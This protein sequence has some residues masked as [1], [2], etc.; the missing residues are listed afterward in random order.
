MY[1]LICKSNPL[2]VGDA[3]LD[4]LPRSDLTYRSYADQSI[5][6]VDLKAS[7]LIGTF[8]NNCRFESVKFDNSDIEGA[9]FIGCDFRNCTF[10]DADIRSCTFS[11]CI[12][13]KCQ[14]DQALLQDTT[15]RDSELIE[16]SFIQASIHDSAFHNSTLNNCSVKHSSALHNTFASVTFKQM[17]IADCTFLY[18]LFVECQFI[19]VQMNVEAIGATYGLSQEN[20]HSLEMIY[21]GELQQT[22]PQDII[23]ALKLSYLDRK[24]EFSEAMLRVNFGPQP[25]LVSLGL[26]VNSLCK[27]AVNG[28]GVKRDEFRFIG[29]VSEYLSEQGKLPV[30][31]LIHATELT[32][33]LLDGAE[34]SEGVRNTVQELHN[35]LFLMLQSAVDEYQVLANNLNLPD[36]LSTPIRLTLTYTERPAIDSAMIIRIAS[37]ANP[38]SNQVVAELVDA[39]PGS[40]IEIVQTTALGVL[41]LYT[42]F[43][44]TNGLLV[45]IIRTR[46]LAKALVQPISKRTIQGFT[47]K[48]I[49][50]N[51]GVAQSKFTRTAMDWLAASTKAT[52]PN[53]DNGRPDVATDLHKLKSIAIEAGG[54]EVA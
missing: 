7:L 44:V 53:I 22:P 51:D 3:L 35:K 40:W 23:E 42:L 16:S 8:F 54:A 41:A 37:K 21:L 48:I 4:L 19:K 49:L 27:I 45:Q 33:Q 6:A 36:D 28:I 32:G 31:F 9:Q 18:T 1:K 43:V 13:G 29:R 25:K 2:V 26:A 20:I 47:K 39:R 52:P 30:G 24:W 11:R 38:D 46:A 12:F 10:L 14:F 5:N 15:I 34:L 50:S 17:R